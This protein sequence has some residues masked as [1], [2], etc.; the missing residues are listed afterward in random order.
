[1]HLSVLSEKRSIGID[2][3]CGVVVQSLG[4]SFKQRAN[5]YD[6]MLLS[7]FTECLRTWARDR[8]GKIEIL[9]IFNLAKIGGSKQFLE[10]NDLSP[11]FCGLFDSLHG[12]GEIRLKI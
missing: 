7:N 2:N 11:M 4:S 8:L 6:F 12:F 1:V 10:A 3:D 9:M 5:N